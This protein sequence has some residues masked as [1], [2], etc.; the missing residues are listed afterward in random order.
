LGKDG[1]D[2]TLFGPTLQIAQEG[3]I[4]TLPKATAFGPNGKGFLVVADQFLPW[5]SQQREV[6]GVRVMP[7]EREWV[8]DKPFSSVAEKGGF[9]GIGSN[10]SDFALAAWEQRLE[11]GGCQL[12][13]RFAIP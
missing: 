3:Q 1:E 12:L 9:G 13:A 10:G 7:T 11:D 2:R 4:L 8:V 6:V 5:Q